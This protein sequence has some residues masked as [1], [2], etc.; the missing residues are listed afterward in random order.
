MNVRQRR[1][2]LESKGQVDSQGTV[3]NK[4]NPHQLGKDSCLYSQELEFVEG[5]SYSDTG[6]GAG[7][8]SGEVVS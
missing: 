3:R 1:R 4:G 7:S 2:E 6:S 5:P 8:L